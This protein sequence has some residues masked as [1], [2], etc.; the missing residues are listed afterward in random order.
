MELYVNYP[1][2][3]KL[4]IPMQLRDFSYHAHL[5]NCLEFSFCTE[6]EVLVSV[7]G[8]VR[9]LVANQGIM[10]PPNSIHSYHTP[11]TSSYYTILVGL[12]VLPELSELLNYKQPARLTF[13][14]DTLLSSLLSDFYASK[15]SYF[16]VKALL[17]RTSEVLTRDN[18]FVNRENLANS[19]CIRIM[20]YIRENFHRELTLEDIARVTGYNY[21]YISKL[22]KKQFGVTFTFLLARYRISYA[23][24]L[25]DQR[26]ESIS[27]IALSS[28][29]GSIRSFNRV[30]KQILGITPIEYRDEHHHLLP[31]TVLETQN[32]E[33]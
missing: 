7:D 27:Q 10:I 33:K 15:Q 17:Y 25:L 29:F 26:K 14:T 22:I 23:C 11:K 21:Q 13:E 12:D 19:P 6:G 3:E 2:M 32:A 16:A 4:L 18:I 5:H 30:F 9:S 20:E 8:S 24:N 28:G 1:E 31:Q